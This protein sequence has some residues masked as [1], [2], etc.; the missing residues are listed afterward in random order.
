MGGFILKHS[1]GNRLRIDPTGGDEGVAIFVFSGH[2]A[3][4]LVQQGFYE[5]VLLARRERLD[6][7]FKIEF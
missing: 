1:A 3:F 7:F 6:C 4:D 5:E 2:A